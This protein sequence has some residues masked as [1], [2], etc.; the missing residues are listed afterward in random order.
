M[1]ELNLEHPC[2]RHRCHRCCVD[3]EMTLTSEDVRRI[4]SIGHRN[5]FFETE[6]GYV[7]LDNRDGNCIFLRA[8]LCTV[9]DHRP[10]GCTLYPLILDT[11]EWVVVLHDFCPHRDEFEFTEGQKKQLARLIE[12]QEDERH[13]RQR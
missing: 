9:Y 2:V 10:E 6:D 1:A 8:G 3:T 5:F 4:S 13:H 7:Q 12:R 11:D